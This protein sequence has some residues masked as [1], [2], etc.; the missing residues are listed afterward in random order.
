MKR[1]MKVIVS[2]LLIMIM[3]FGNSYTSYAKNTSIHLHIAKGLVS[4]ISGKT[5]EVV[6]LHDN[7]PTEHK[8]LMSTK[9]NKMYTASDN[10]EYVTTKISHFLIGGVIY[11]FGPT[12]EVVPGTEGG[13][14]INCDLV[15]LPEVTLTY[16]ANGA[17]TGMPPASQTMTIYSSFIVS[18]NT[19]SLGKTGHIF[20]GWNTAADG[21][22]ANYV[23]GSSRTIGIQSLTLFAQWKPV[24][25]VTYHANPVEGFT[26]SGSSPFDANMYPITQEV[27]VKGKGSLDLANHTFAGWTLTSAGEGTVYVANNKIPM[28]E[29]GLDF[30]AKWTMNDDYSVFYDGN[31]N[32]GGSAPLD[33][34]QY[35]E[36]ETVTV[37]NNSG[38]L[39][40]TG[41]SFAGWNT[42]ASG[43]GILRGEGTTFTMGN[44]DVVLYALWKPDS[45]N[46]KYYNVTYDENG[47]EGTPPEDSND[48]GV[49]DSVTVKSSDISKTGFELSGWA[50]NPAGTGT[51]FKSLDVFTMPN[52]DVTLYAVWAPIYKVTYYSNYEDENVPIDNN[53]YLSGKK[54]TVLGEITR[55]NFDFINWNTSVDGSGLSYDPG[56]IFEIDNANVSL[57]AQW[58]EHEKFQVIYDG[59]GATDGEVPVDNGTYYSGENSIVLGKNNLQRAGFEFI[60]WNTSANGSGT[61]YDENDN[62]V[63]STGDI[64]LYAMWQIEEDNPPQPT[65]PSEEPPSEEPPTEQ[66][67]T[68]EPTTAASTEQLD[69]E[70]VALSTPIEFFNID[71]YLIEPNFDEVV[72]IEIDEPTPLGSALPQTGQLPA[73]LFYGI[74]G[75]ITAAGAFM[76]KRK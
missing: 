65:T 59:N 20:T 44:S 28:V 17:D 41:Y 34:N 74:G 32:T 7:D 66:P 19:G 72:E 75:L 49:G 21:S 24:Y 76:K 70:P 3:I 15:K 33:E 64:V 5:V 31:G 25:P 6:V 58:D 2:L 68:P 29:G 4:V 62:L 36:G 13:G 43:G 30:Y 56:D 40:K 48:Y 11:T 16:D 47:G 23:I 69:E 42:E 39:L 9:N 27:T 63:F 53:E 73:E 55:V 10:G 61:S 45:V 22:G 57:Y 50:K 71:Q 54:V 38:A 52:N 14:T 26:L 51:I 60:N 18:D 8:I 37:F 35:F 46:Q 67:P 12:G 1:K